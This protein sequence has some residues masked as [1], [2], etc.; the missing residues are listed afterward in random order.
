MSLTT[1][2]PTFEQNEFVAEYLCIRMLVCCMGTERN[3]SKTVGFKFAPIFRELLHDLFELV[4]TLNPVLT[5]IQLDPGT[6][7]V[8]C[9]AFFS[10]SKKWNTHI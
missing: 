10:C 9:K 4:V 1:Q 2:V 7:K 5:Q 3:S 8:N 6:L